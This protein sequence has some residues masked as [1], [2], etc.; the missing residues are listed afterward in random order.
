VARMLGHG[1]LDMVFKH[2]GKYIRNRSRKDGG[3]FLEGLKSDIV[4]PSTLLR[5]EGKP[6]RRT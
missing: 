3:R 2:Y 6:W 5:G 1:S 4:V